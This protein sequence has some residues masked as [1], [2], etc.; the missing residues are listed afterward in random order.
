AARGGP[1]RRAEGAAARG[2]GRGEVPRS[3]GG[4][5]GPPAVPSQA[6]KP[7]LPNFRNAAFAVFRQIVDQFPSPPVIEKTESGRPLAQRSKHGGR[8]PED[9]HRGHAPGVARRSGAWAQRP[10]VADTLPGAAGR[11]GVRGL[12]AAGRARWS[13]AWAGKPPATPPTPKTPFRPPSWFSF[14]RP[15]RFHRARWLPTGCTAWPA[16]RP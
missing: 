5:Q 15:P 11:G 3:R 12:G 10:A 1:R 14:A 6:R 9:G 16:R 7:A 4:G 13:G 8:R 2:E